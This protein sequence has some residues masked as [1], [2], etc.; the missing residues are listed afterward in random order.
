MN[1]GLV[2]IGWG[3]GFFMTRLAGTIK[4]MTGSLDYAFYLS[5]LVLIVAVVVSWMT[6]RPMHVASGEIR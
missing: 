3:L 5:A 2:F 6:K 1:Y 4:D